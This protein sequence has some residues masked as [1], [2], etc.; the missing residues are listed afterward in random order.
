M[1]RIKQ[2]LDRARHERAGLAGR[3]GHRQQAKAAGTLSRI[4]YTMTR[5]V[6]VSGEVLH[7][8]RI[9]TAFPPG[10]YSDAYKI[11]RTQ[12]LQRM[13]EHGW[14]VLMVAATCPGEGATLTAINLAAS[15]ALEVS[16]SVL[17]VDA[18]LR[19][20]SAHNYF[21]LPP[22]RGLADYLL[23]DL[24]LEEVL[25]HP[26]GMERFVLLPGGRPLANSAEMLNSPRMA[27]LVDELKHRYA[28]RLVVF[29]LPPVLA[30]ADAL[31]FTP[32][33]DAALLV[34]EEGHTRADDARRAVD[35]LAGTQI[36]GT[37]LN[38]ARD[39]A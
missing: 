6:Q 2:A 38:K 23:D 26:S 35:L 37:V 12:V 18:N 19:A 16:Q 21:G 11:L 30:S 1:E 5:T 13:N 10:P 36:L 4:D 22:G 27:A 9:V 39:A 7:H 25:L 29:D 33:A 32:L 15:L 17:M 3:E 28:G 20:P 14:N 34:L 8:N 31:A 24:P